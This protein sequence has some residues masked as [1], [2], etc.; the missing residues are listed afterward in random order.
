MSINGVSSD[1]MTHADAVHLVQNSPSPLR[2]LMMRHMTGPTDQQPTNH[3][4]GTTAHLY[5]D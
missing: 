5:V 4:T 2:L 3:N 1:G